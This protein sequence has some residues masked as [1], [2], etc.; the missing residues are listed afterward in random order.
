MLSDLSE[1]IRNSDW[2]LT[3]SQVKGYMMM[4]LK[5]LAFCHQNSIMHRDLKPANLLISSTGHLKIADFGLARV[6]SNEGDRL[7]SHQV[8]T[9]WYR[10]PELLYGA[11]KYDEG[12]DICLTPSNRLL[13][14]RI[15][16]YQ[17]TSGSPLFD[18]PGLCEA[19]A[20]YQCSLF[21]Q[22]I[23]E[24]PD[25]NKI[26]FK[27]NPPIPLEHVVPDASP[28]A[29]DLLKRFLVYPSKQR[30]S[31][32]EALLHPY[33]FKE[34]LPAHHSELPIPQRAG[35][36]TLQHQHEF[37]IEQ[38]LVESVTDPDL[39]SCHARL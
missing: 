14:S 34:P 32:A 13:W 24:L 5:G 16:I 28:E 11:R 4:L 17:R 10:A 29:V 36:K 19:K 38:P 33:F 20:L 8:A 27:E 7:Y 35:R 23:T 18:C 25:Y 1:V 15:S 12:V 21:I 26:T 6:F 30:I 22:E 3:E 9:R 37:H 39:V 2:P 31:A